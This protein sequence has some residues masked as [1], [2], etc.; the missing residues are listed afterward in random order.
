MP[1]Q[2][3]LPEALR[4]RGLRVELVP[5]WE[6]RGGSGFRPRGAVCHWTAGARTGDRPSLNVV[7][8]GRDDLPG[9]LANVFL[10]RSG[11]A[12]V[13]AAGT[14]NHA[15]RGGWRGLEGNSSVFGT[16]AENSGNGEWTAAQRDAY[17]R[18]NAAFCDLGG[19][20]PE[21][22]CGHNEWTPRKVD[23]H[24][25]TM[26]VMRA[27]VAAVL[28][29]AAPQGEDEDMTPAQDA[30]LAAIFNALPRINQ[31]LEAV[32]KRTGAADGNLKVAAD[33]VG[34]I[35]TRVTNYLDAKVS[36]NLALT[37]AVLGLVDDEPVD[38]EAVAQTILDAVGPGLAVEVQKALAGLTATTKLTKEPN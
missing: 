1:Y 38:A 18:I 31:I 14:A 27:Q 16:E 37:R 11:V 25:Y 6:R 28:R 21:M 8:N 3:G 13:V 12:I 22:V 20:G 19:F 32:D 23:I 7:V 34:A 29:G 33:Q 15:G 26:P 36:E 9:P 24:D 30:A 5:G 4:R 17:P 2:T 35:H 10:T